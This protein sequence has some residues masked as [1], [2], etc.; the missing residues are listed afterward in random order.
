M[1]RCPF[2]SPTMAALA[3]GPGDVGQGDVFTQPLTWAPAMDFN[4]T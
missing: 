4:T 2:H 3:N 1:D